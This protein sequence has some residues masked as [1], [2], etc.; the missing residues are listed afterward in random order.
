M[1]PM[2]QICDDSDEGT[3][4]CLGGSFLDFDGVIARTKSQEAPNDQGRSQLRVC[5]PGTG[6]ESVKCELRA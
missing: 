1:T 2:M 4:D 6:R 3:M 5:L